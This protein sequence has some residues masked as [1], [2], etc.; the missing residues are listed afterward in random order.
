MVPLSMHHPLALSPW[1]D[2]RLSFSSILPF[3]H[4]AILSTIR[5]ATILA[6]IS[7]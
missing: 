5:A 7:R 3:I 2:R 6:E 4:L 1:W